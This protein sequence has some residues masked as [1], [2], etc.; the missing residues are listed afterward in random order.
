M[1]TRGLVNH[2]DIKRRCLVVHAP[3]AVDELE[4]PTRDEVL[5]Y[6]LLRLRL[7]FPPSGEEPDLDVNEAA[8]RVVLEA[9]YDSVDDV[10]HVAVEVLVHCDL[11]ARVVMGVR[12]EVN[13]ELSRINASRRCRRG[14]RPVHRRV[15]GRRGVR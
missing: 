3:S 9:R 14:I 5:H 10:I 8:V 12:N 4:L 6:R 1:P 2:L 13:V 11:P 15:V 7:R